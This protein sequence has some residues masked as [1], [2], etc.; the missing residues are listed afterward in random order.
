MRF[1]PTAPVTETIV[2]KRPIASTRIEW[3]TMSPS[4][5]A[6]S[7]ARVATACF[8]QNMWA[9]VNAVKNKF[10]RGRWCAAKK[11]SG[12]FASSFISQKDV[13]L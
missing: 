3:T 5:G 6:R 1:V 9:A 12:V 13:A 10:I 8:V 2:M 4:V 7:T 11:V